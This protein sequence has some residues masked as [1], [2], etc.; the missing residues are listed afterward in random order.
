[1]REVELYSRLGKLALKVYSGSFLKTGKSRSIAWTAAPSSN[2]RRLGSGEGRTDVVERRVDDRRK[3]LHGGNGTK[4]DQGRDKGVLNQ[5]LTRLIVDQVDQQVLHVLHVF[6]LLFI[7]QLSLSG[8]WVDLR[9]GTPDRISNDAMVLQISLFVSSG[10]HR[11]SEAA[12]A[13]ALLIYI[14]TSRKDF[15]PHDLERAR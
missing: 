9:I 10:L 11:P 13:V 8:R 2:R 7:F 12:Q 5:V 15:S 4:A 6:V 1:V 3:A 14:G